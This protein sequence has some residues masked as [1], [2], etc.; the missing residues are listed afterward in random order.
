MKGFL[1]YTAMRFGV[2]LATY[3]LVVGVYL[4]VTD[5]RSLPILWPLILAA[6][7][8]TLVSVYLLRGPRDRLAAGV[9]A[10]AERMSAR[11]EQMR[12]KEDTD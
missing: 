11:Y 9:Q 4:L 5:G 7:L 6:V 10:R 8:S 2:F 1:L 3:A 12:S